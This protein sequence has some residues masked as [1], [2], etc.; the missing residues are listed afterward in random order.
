MFEKITKN[1]VAVEKISESLLIFEIK[2]NKKTLAKRT[3]KETR[4]QNNK[5]FE[6]VNLTNNVMGIMDMGSS[7]NSLIVSE[8]STNYYPG[9][10]PIFWWPLQEG[11]LQKLFFK[12]CEFI[13][14]Y[15]PYHFIKKLKESGFK[16]KHT[17]V[18]WHFKI[19]RLINGKTLSIND[20]NF[21]ISA[22]TY[23]LMK[24]EIVIET[25][26]RLIERVKNGEIINNSSIVLEMTHI[27][28]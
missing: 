28:I 26:Q 17:G 5:I 27:A 8:L 4:I 25:L 9:G 16:I 12:E 23:H 13:I 6:R 2:N 1:K 24:E 22:I 15:N 21:F 10:T 11:V 19:S 20:T 18:K 7:E 3:L 14:I